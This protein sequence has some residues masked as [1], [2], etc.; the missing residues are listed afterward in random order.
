MLLTNGQQ[1][2]LT[3][4]D[5][6]KLTEPKRL[7][8]VF[9]SEIEDIR[10]TLERL[11]SRGAAIAFTINE[12]TGRDRTTNAIT[13]V[14]A[15]YCELDGIP[16]HTD[17]QHKIDELLAG[18]LPPS[19]IVETRNGLHAYWYSNGAEAVDPLDY[20]RINNRIAV[21]HNGDTN[22]L[23]ISRV[24]RLPDFKHMKN[25]DDPF[26]VSVVYEDQ[27][28]IYTR[29]DV[30]SAFPRTSDEDAQTAPPKSRPITLDSSD[31]ATRYLQAALRRADNE[32][33]AVAP[34]SGNRNN[35]LNSS[36]YS[37][38]RYLHTG[39]I[40]ETDIINALKPAA[41]SI[42]LPEHEADNTLKSAMNAG[43][44]R[45]RDIKL[46]DKGSEE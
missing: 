11:N 31:R 36:A 20:R 15:Y 18:P 16:H 39:R 28:A 42:G 1:T 7:T 3:Y 12:T 37:L 33:R 13:R 10:P 17:K 9:R 2:I 45:P 30:F 22:S 34:D 5:S 19:A 40:T 29:E 41:L 26:H 44:R 27:E 43:A 35:T 24:L 8:K 6:A 38:A 32:L 25:P 23:D 4:A 21:F 14:R 46:T